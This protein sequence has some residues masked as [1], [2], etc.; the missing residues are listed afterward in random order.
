MKCYQKEGPNCHKKITFKNRT[1]FTLLLGEL[2]KTG[3]DGKCAISF[4]EFKPGED[5][6]KQEDNCWE[7]NLPIEVYI[8][9]PEKF[10]REGYISCDSIEIKNKV[11]KH[12]ILTLDYLHQN[13]WTVIY[14]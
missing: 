13:N 1:D 11:L 9:S 10:H 2:Y 7:E 8:V 5:Y 12:Y 3:G 14:E 6:E 4:K